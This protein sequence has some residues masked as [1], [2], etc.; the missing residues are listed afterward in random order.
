MSTKCPLYF[1]RMG[2]NPA[3]QGIGGRKKKTLNPESKN[4][5]ELGFSTFLQRG[6]SPVIQIS[7][8]KVIIDRE[9]YE[10][11]QKKR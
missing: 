1:Y 10:K 11:L 4:E 9:E 6:A 8:D 5:L 7:G 2:R 3:R